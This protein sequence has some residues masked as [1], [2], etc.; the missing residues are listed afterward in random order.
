MTDDDFGAELPTVLESLC[1]YVQ[2]GELDDLEEPSFD[3]AGAVCRLGDG[4]RMKTF[5]EGLQRAGCHAQILRV[6]A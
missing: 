6:Y 3:V 5:D 1:A 4:R 2:Q